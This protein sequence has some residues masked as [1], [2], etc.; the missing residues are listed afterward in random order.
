MAYFND[1]PIVYYKFGN[2]N[3]FNL[4][5]NISAYVDIVDQLKENAAFY[6]FYTIKDGERPDQLSQMLYG[7]TDY[8]WTFYSLNEDL[9]QFGWPIQTEKVTDFVKK[10]YP[11]TTLV[12]RDYFF[13][14]FNI[15]ERVQGTNSGAIG[16]VLNKVS[17]FGHIVIK[18]DD[19]FDDGEEVRTIDRD[20]D[21]IRSITLL[22]SMPEYLSPHH[23]E[24]GGK[25][26]DID[27]TIPLGSEVV[28]ITKTEYYSNLNEER[29]VIRVFRDNAIR[30]IVSSFNK[31][32]REAPIE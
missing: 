27:P 1:F 19:E 9:K 16:T 24:S 20:S 22:N 21:D 4:F 30:N 23:F 10:K 8:Y 15:G 29:K 2:E 12:T 25:W 17:D 7:S 5:Q 18:T 3:E 11:N 14:K 26:I 28:P 13:D 31:A 32:L 6:T